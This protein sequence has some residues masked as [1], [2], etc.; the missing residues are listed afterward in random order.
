MCPGLL[1][2][3]EVGEGGLGVAESRKENP[4]P[5]LVSDLDCAITI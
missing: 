4:G 2:V 3:F 1:E 5:N